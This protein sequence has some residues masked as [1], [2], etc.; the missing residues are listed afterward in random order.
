MTIRNNTSVV[1][2]SKPL[3]YKIRPMHMI[4]E[5]TSESTIDEQYMCAMC[6]KE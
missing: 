6:I 3:I 5:T 1:N 2:S 4:Y